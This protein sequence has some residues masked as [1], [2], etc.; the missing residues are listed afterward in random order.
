MLEYWYIQRDLL[1]PVYKEESCNKK[2]KWYFVNCTTTTTTPPPTSP[3]PPPPP[4]PTATNHQ[5][6]S[7]LH[8]H[9]TTPADTTTTRHYHNHQAGH[10]CMPWTKKY[11]L[12]IYILTSSSL[13]KL[14]YPQ[15]SA[16]EKIYPNQLCKE[17]TPCQA[18][19][20]WLKWSEKKVDWSLDRRGWRVTELTNHIG[21]IL[22]YSM[23]IYF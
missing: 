17:V 12:Y 20:N 18:S 2:K 9:R 3:P 7:P 5:P 4:Q 21:L 23:S 11:K 6:L 1:G 15:P 10:H 16:E 8:R 19:V 22:R 14:H 13:L